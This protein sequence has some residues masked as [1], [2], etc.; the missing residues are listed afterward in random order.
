MFSFHGVGEA[1]LHCIEGGCYICYIALGRCYICWARNDLGS[2]TAH[3]LHI[4]ATKLIII[5][6]DLIISATLPLQKDHHLHFHSATSWH[7]QVYI[8]CMAATLSTQPHIYI[9]FWIVNSAG[10]CFKSYYT[11]EH[12]FRKPSQLCA[13]INWGLSGISELLLYLHQNGWNTSVDITFLC[14][15]HLKSSNYILLHHQLAEKATK[16]NSQTSINP[17]SRRDIRFKSVQI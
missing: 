16:L 15:I 14:V 6:H 11:K 13:W 12:F 1:M 17:C 3:W 9:D 2:A 4:K 10:V 8:L 7:D 5:V